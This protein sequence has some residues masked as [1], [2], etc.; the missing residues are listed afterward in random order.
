MWPISVQ[1]KVLEVSVAGYREHFVGRASDL[2]DA[3]G[4]TTRCW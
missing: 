2:S 1:C 4:A 3:I